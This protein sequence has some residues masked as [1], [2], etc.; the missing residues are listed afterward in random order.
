M[1][2]S[3]AQVLVVIHKRRYLVGDSSPLGAA[4]HDFTHRDHPSPVAHHHSTVV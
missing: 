4:N 2:M 1:N 3:L